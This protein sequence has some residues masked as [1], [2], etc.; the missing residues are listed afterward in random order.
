M[1]KGAYG[2][3]Y[4]ATTKEYPNSVRAIKV[5]HKKQIKNKQALIDEVN[6]LKESDHPSIVKIYETF[7][8]EKYLCL[9]LEYLFV[10]F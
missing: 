3:V 9:V 4:K 5:I 1:G 2:T 6:I 10:S 7:E 8:D